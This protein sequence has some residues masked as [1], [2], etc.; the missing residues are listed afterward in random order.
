MQHLRFGSPRWAAF[1]TFTLVLTAHGAAVQ[2]QTSPTLTEPTPTDNPTPAAPSPTE[3]QAPAQVLVGELVVTGVSGEL[4]N[5]V[6]KTIQTQP[7][8]TTTVEQLQADV[9]NLYRTGLYRN[10]LVTPEDTPLGVR[11]TFAVDPN[12]VLTKVSVQAVA[13]QPDQT[14][15]PQ[16]ELDKIFGDL[17]GQRLNFNDFQ[18]N[19]DRIQKVETWYKN[20][21]FDLAKI[22][23]LD[24]PTSDGQ[25]NLM[26]V[27]GMV[28][29]VKVRFV[30]S[31]GKEKK[32]KTKEYVIRRQLQLKTGQVFNRDVAQGDLRR[33]FDLGLFEDVKISFEPGSNPSQVVVNYDMVEGNTG[34]IAAGAGIS[35]SSGLFGTISY[36]QKNIAGRNQQLSTDFQLGT[37]ELLFDT[38][39]TDPWIKGDPKRTSYTINAFR[40]QSISLIFD[41]GKKS[42]PLKVSGDTPRVVRTGGGVSFSRPLKPDALGNSVWSASAG[43]NYQ[44][45][46][47][48]NANGKREFIDAAGQNLSFSK[49]GRDDLLTLELGLARDLRNNKLQPTSG[50]L[51]RL[52][53]EQTI[54]V[55]LGN[56]F[57]NRLRGSYSYYVPVQWL[58]FSKDQKPQALAFNVQAGTVLGDLPPYEAFSLGGSNSVRGFDE[59][60]VG[61]GRS[62]FQATAEY[63]FPI[64]SIVGGALFADYG[65]DLGTGKDVPAQ[66]GLFRG[67]PGNGFGYGVGVRVQSPLGAI[68]IDYG[69][70]SDG[71]NR[72]HFG[73]GERF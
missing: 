39:F 69:L 28:E 73:I 72:I 2:A 46:A 37:R 53:V 30:D 42:V 33:L 8:K 17:Y 65:T 13:A 45:V 20:N 59:G 55:G 49:T 52:G 24:T 67:K 34:S 68:R 19:S 26:M 70:A 16:A 61:S 3:T 58:K 25:V 54:P 47:I 38:S 43:L 63:R 50:S 35:S 32:G 7:G 4:E 1:L 44:R 29:D 57:M 9:N 15:I 21:G 5:L 6:Y 27:Q 56:I 22:V 11:I 14:L 18:T 48:T 23:D 71:G 62:Y 41:N 40:R 12:P 31:E 36:Q 10:V 66:P 64:F 51:L 60:T